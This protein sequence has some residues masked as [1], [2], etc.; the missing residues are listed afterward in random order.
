MSAC[1]LLLFALSFAMGS[2][3]AP[4]V[5]QQVF[6]ILAVAATVLFIL[7]GVPPPGGGD[8]ERSPLFNSLCASSAARYVGKVSYQLYLWHWPAILC[9]RQLLILLDEFRAVPRGPIL[10]VMAL[11]ALATTV[12]LVAPLLSY[13]VIEAPLRAWTLRTRHG[14]LTTIAAMLALI[15]A[16]GAWMVLLRTSLDETIA[17]SMNHWEK[18]PS[19][20][21]S[22]Q[23]AA[24]E[25]FVES[26]FAGVSTYTSQGAG[27]ATFGAG[28]TTVKTAFG[29]SLSGGGCACRFCDGLTTTHQPRQLTDDSNA[30][31]CFS[32]YPL[33]L[34]LFKQFSC[35]TARVDDAIVTNEMTAANAP[36]IFDV[37]AATATRCLKPDR[38]AA[39]LPSPTLFLLGT[40]I[41]A[42]L[43]AGLA[44][45]VRGRYQIRLF[46]QAA[47]GILPWNGT[48]Y[49][50]HGKVVPQF[51][52]RGLN[53]V[54]DHV[55]TL[56]TTYMEPGDL[57]CYLIDDDFWL[58]YAGQPSITHRFEKELIEDIV[59]R[60]GGSTIVFSSWP[61][62]NQSTGA[63][64][65]SSAGVSRQSID[66]MVARHATAHHISMYSLF[67]S[68]SSHS[69]PDQS[70][71]SCGKTV[72]GTIM[73]AY[74]DTEH[75]NTAGSIYL[76]PHLCDM[77]QALDVLL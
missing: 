26:D 52:A 10:V 65:R 35:F 16:G 12:G 25:N 30:S 37:V 1:A 50:P 53:S 44:Y 21:A 77:M 57:L 7:A 42:S 62:Y 43:Q 64:D 68:G 38:S 46:A 60:N 33:N 23:R 45:A 67:C 15:F 39:S 41:S 6:A 8:T 20:P 11:G 47:F 13:H 28:S 75:L 71:D 19:C 36:A 2:G 4:D 56:L 66:R 17:F 32:T 63:L 40:S 34:A 54:Y 58:P 51:A 49:P 3:A 74:L 72:P 61:H 69:T 70:G 9:S 18:T 22:D 31:L 73:N 5:V 27:T 14:H 59:E 24:F 48:S 76:W 29:R 55:R